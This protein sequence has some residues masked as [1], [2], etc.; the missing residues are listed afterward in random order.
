MDE[1]DVLSG[2]ERLR[3]GDVLIFDGYPW[4]VVKV[5]PS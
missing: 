5:N 2:N 4:I 3:L 1:T